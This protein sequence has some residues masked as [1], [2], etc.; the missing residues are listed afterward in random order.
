MG[1][2]CIVIA[3]VSLV[4]RNK[5]IFLYSSVFFSGF[6]G[7]SV[8]TING[9]IS[10]QPAYVL[11]FAYAI[12]SIRDL[13]KAKFDK[14]YLFFFVY[15]VIGS[16]LPILLKSDNIL[17]MLQ[18]GSYGAVSY[19][20]SNLIHVAY[21]A[22]TFIFFTCLDATKGNVVKNNVFKAYKYGIYAFIFV[23]A[24]QM[25]AFKLNLPFDVIFRQN[26]NGNIQ[27]TRLYGPCGEASM[28]AYYLAPSLLFLW[29]SK[30]NW[31]DVI[32]FLIG[33]LFGFISYSSTFFIG[34]CFVVLF[35]LV[36]HM[37]VSDPGDK[38]PIMMCLAAAVV[39]LAI[40]V[41][42]G[43]DLVSYAY[44]GLIDKLNEKSFSGIERAASFRNMFQIGLTYP[45]G[46]G[47]GTSRS[48]DLL[49][50]W[51]CNIGVVGIIIFAA[52]IIHFYKKARKIHNPYIYIYTDDCFDDDCGSGAVCAI[53]Q[54]LTLFWNDKEQAGVRSTPFRKA[55][56]SLC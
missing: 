4:C 3:L 47:F 37:L 17:V 23:V 35:I 32:M 1:Y 16:F 12:L 48:K 31:L 25:V 34:Y 46:V 18:S 24:Y 45:F 7:S 55:G 51:M 5:H 13:S 2:I 11:F 49:S 6:T 22:I 40:N 33:S 21:L 29:I 19:T 15:C 36:R 41:F 53:H 14:F 10:I 27:G 56:G 30:R 20:A 9:D 8:V 50:T 26:V 38:K 39:A 43:N 52:V 42:S 28:M 44:N 54:S